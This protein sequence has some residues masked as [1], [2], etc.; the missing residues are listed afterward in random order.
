LESKRDKTILLLPFVVNK[1]YQYKKYICKN[2]F[3]VF[4]NSLKNMFFTFFGS[5]DVFMHVFKNVFL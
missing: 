4:Y 3:H 1:A 2:V 5:F